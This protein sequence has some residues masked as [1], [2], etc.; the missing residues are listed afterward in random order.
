MVIFVLCRLLL[1]LITLFFL[2]FIGFSLGYFTPH[3]SLQGAPLWNVWVFRLNSL[4]HWDPGVSG[5]NGQLISEQL[6]EVFPVIIGL[7]TLAFGFALMVGIPV[8]MLA[9][10][11]RNK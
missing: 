3:V 10:I 5:I 6:E 9:G 7:C 11:T 8:D 4:V 2:T 1:L